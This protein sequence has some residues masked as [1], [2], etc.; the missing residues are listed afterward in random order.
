MPDI[1]AGECPLRISFAH[2]DRAIVA[3][4]WQQCGRAF[5]KSTITTIGSIVDVDDGPPNAP[6]FVLAVETTS[7]HDARAFVDLCARATA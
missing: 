3:A 1:A 5:P 6:V 4:V 7:P 2:T